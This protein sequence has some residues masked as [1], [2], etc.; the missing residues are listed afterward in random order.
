[1]RNRFTKELA[2]CGF[3]SVQAI[4]EYSP[5]KVNRLFLREDRLDT[6]RSLCHDL[7]ERRRAYKLC[8]DE[9]LEKICKS[10][11]HQGVVAMIHEPVI[12]PV[13][14]NDIATWANEGCLLLLLHNVGN[15]NN[16]GAIVRSAAFFGVKHIILCNKRLEI[17]EPHL[18]TAAYRVAEGGMEHVKLYVVE[19]A[20]GFLKEAG[21]RFLTC[22]TALR[23]RNRLSDLVKEIADAEG[24]GTGHKR[25]L[26]V[27][28]GNEEDGLPPDVIDACRRVIHITGAG[29]VESLNVSTAAGIVMQNLYIS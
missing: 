13:T 5:E 6:F 21:K 27:A 18:S 22:A 10:K 15:D 11:A 12:E 16:L 26:L 23:V 28:F 9:E 4:A 2:V 8:A 19:D 1:M 24:G 7:A 25:T 29:L 3:R 14:R 17:G 20:V